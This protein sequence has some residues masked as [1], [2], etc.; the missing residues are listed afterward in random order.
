[1]RINKDIKI[2]KDFLEAK[3]N[4]NVTVTSVAKKH[5]ITRNGLYELVARV[6]GG[7]ES[8]ILKEL[9]RARL[10]ILWKHKYQARIQA[11]PSEQ[12]HYSG[13]VIRQILKE[14]QAD[15]FPQTEIAKYVGRQ[16]STVIYH[17]NK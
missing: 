10:D 16:R 17:L 9:E 14:M 5:G 3:Y 6:E 7:S 15:G 11:L 2:Y 4:P 13:E 12:K 1:M 8:K